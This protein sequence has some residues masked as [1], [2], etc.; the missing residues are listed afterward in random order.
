MSDVTPT[1]TPDVLDCLAN[2]R[3]PDVLRLLERFRS[4]YGWAGRE[5]SAPSSY[6]SARRENVF[7]APL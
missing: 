6:A 3:H 7:G 1:R 4:P 5:P 2:L